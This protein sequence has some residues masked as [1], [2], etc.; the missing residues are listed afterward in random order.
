MSKYVIG[1][2]PDSKAHG[3]AVYRN[4]KLEA[5]DC[6]P[7]MSILAMLESGVI[8]AGCE[9]HI[10]N[11]CA[12]NAAF[13]KG[14]IRNA[15]AG[16]AVSRSLG[17]VQ[18][19]QVELERMIER[20]GLKITHHKISKAWKK[21]KVMFERVTGWTGRSNEDTR[22]AAYFGFLGAK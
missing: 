4:G 3:V 19:S 10:E 12:N 22:S 17:M 11:V 16:S 6:M 9:F 21:D 8:G 18:Q 15:K 1:I 13:V 14:G 7:L 2:D 5:L 20:F